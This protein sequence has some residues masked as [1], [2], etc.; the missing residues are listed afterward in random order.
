ML[1]NNPAALA[2]HE[3]RLLYPDAPIR[4]LASFG[5]GAFEPTEALRPG[6]WSSTVQMLVRAATRTEEIHQLLAEML[7]LLSIPYFRFNPNVPRMS[8]DET[9]PQKLAELQALGRA[10]VVSGGGKEECAA[11]AQVLV[12][13]G[14]PPARGKLPLRAWM[15]LKRAIAR[16][17]SSVAKIRSRL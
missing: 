5:T 13:R 12:G 3:A 14:V 2:M 16:A 11:L 6:S 17:G 4:C 15:T 7:P 10:H 9:S 8:L 1:A